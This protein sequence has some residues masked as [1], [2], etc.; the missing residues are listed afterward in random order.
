METFFKGFT[1]EHIE[2]AKNTEADGL[3]KALP[4]IA[5]LPLDAFFQVTEDPS[6]KTVELEPRMINIIQ[7]EDW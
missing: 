3:A 7:G 2:R 6:V 1:E 4:K 5:E